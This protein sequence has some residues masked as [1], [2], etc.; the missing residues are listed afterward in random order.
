MWHIIANPTAG[1]GRTKAALPKIT[2]R[3]E[4]HG[5]AHKIILTHSPGH[6]TELAK[7]LVASGAT[8]IAAA[9]GDG[10]VHEV[11][12]G[13]VG[14]SAT[15]AVIPTGTGNDLARALN[16]PLDASEAINVLTKAPTHHIDYGLDNDGVFSVILG[17]G[18][19]AQVMDHVNK[20]KNFLRGPLAIAAA[21]F[22]VV[23]TLEATEME[24]I[25]D[26]KSMLRRTVAVFV[27]NSCWTGGGMYVTPGAKLNDGLFS[28]CFVNELG[29]LELLRLLPK[30]YS[31]GHVGHK[32]VETHCCRELVINTA[33]PMIKMFD[34][35]VYGQSPINAKIVPK[36]LNVLSPGGPALC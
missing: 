12:N 29:K 18:F 23:N 24:L 27:M 11:I 8:T 15:L 4:A 30:V 19:T 26:G 7:N 25:L 16:I 6:A 21:V 2:E 9:G 34:G 35:N 10:T 14:S 3:L 32:S 28:V 5:I 22:K 17:L 31:G 13:M 33:K 20:N 36:G 1:R